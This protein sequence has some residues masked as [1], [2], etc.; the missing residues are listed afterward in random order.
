VTSLNGFASAT[1]L[2]VSGLPAG[3]GG[4][5]APNPVTPPA[6]GSAGSTLSVTTSVSTPSGTYP[7]TI[8]GTSGAL[9]HATGVTLVVQPPGGGNQ[10]LTY[11]ASPGLAIPDNNTTG[12]TS[13]I[14][15]PTSMT[16]TTVSVNVSITHTYQGDLEVSLIGPD[17]TTVLLHNRTGAGT[18]NIITTY[19]ITTRSSQSLA[20]FTGKNT[21]GAW[22]LKVR[23]LAAIDVG[24]LSSWKVAFNGYVTSAPALAIPDNNTTGVTSTMNVTA[25]GTIADLR[26]RVNITHTYKGDLEVSLIGPDNTT[27]LLHNRTGGSTDN[28]STVFPD[29][30]APAQSLAAFNGKPTN[31][32]WKLKVRDLASIDVGTLNSWEIDFR[33]P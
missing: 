1:T 21:S 6:G 18:D 26:V 10:V 7:L 4:S 16:I 31:G 13:T 2:S 20:A 22:R 12:V 9:A 24:T 17:N 27:V 8:T 25:T 30:T 33:T 32:A 15:V 3:A 5:F 14:N 23:D 28:V 19:N 29:L 11:A